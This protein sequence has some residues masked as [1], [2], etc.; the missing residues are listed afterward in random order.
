MSESQ[1]D[2]YIHPDSGHRVSLFEVATRSRAFF[3]LFALLIQLLFS[4]MYHQ[5]QIIPILLRGGVLVAA[6]FMTADRKNHLI[7]G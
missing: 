3:L 5:G 4:G 1:E 2:K 7:V 6:I